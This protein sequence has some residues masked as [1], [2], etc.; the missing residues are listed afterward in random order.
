MQDA[1]CCGII[2]P[3]M[4]PIRNRPDHFTQHL[5]SPVKK[6]LPY[7]H[8]AIGSCRLRGEAVTHLCSGLCGLL[9]FVGG[10]PLLRPVRVGGY[11]PLSR[12]CQ[13]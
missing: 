8:G 10:L 12:N 3:E 1:A 9:L 6:P 11:R 2:V 7:R 13:L 4:Q 5:A